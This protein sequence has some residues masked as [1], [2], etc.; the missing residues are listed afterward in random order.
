MQN[1]QN[2]NEMKTFKIENDFIGYLNDSET[3]NSYMEAM[4][5][6]IEWVK[7]DSLDENPFASQ[8]P[9]SKWN[10]CDENGKIIF[11]VSTKKILS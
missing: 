5:E 7:L 6:L 9:K 3:Y 1:E 10:I 8:Y 2:T 4:I 11:S